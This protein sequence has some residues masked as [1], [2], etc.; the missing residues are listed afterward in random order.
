LFSSGDR[1]RL[2][3]FVC[4]TFLFQAFGVQP[5]LPPSLFRNIPCQAPAMAPHLT[6]QEQDRVVQLKAKGKEPTFILKKINSL[7]H[8]RGVHP[9]AVDA[10]RR[11]LRG[12]THLRARPETRGRK[13]TFSK[14]MV[15]KLN[16]TRKALVKKADGDRQIRWKD[17]LRSARAKKA[18]RTTAKRAFD[19]EGLKVA[20]R[21][22][23]MK[24][25]RT[26]PQEDA[27]M[28]HCRRWRFLPSGYFN[29]SVDLIIDN[30]KFEVPTTDRARAYVK[31]Q[32][33]R[34]QLRTPQEGLKPG[35]TRPNTKK[36]RMHTGGYASVCAGI[37]G[38]KV[39]FWHYLQK[40]WNGE[41]AAAL[42]R[43]PIQSIL[44]KHRGE[45]K[46]YLVCEDNDRTGYK[47]RK[48][49]AAKVESSIQ[50][51]DLPKYSPDLNPLDF[52]VWSEVERRMNKAK[53]KQPESQ[54]KYKARLRRTA[55]GLPA[56]MVKAAVASMKKR[57]Q[58]VYEANGKDIPQ[59]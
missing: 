49:M 29:D 37:S 30:K 21:T 56:S 10:V 14:H 12:K 8:G 27:R 7:R 24:P 54:A 13:R 11:A 23:R 39:V 44:K 31:R 55:L 3:E 15:K 41:A 1:P 4:A 53:V 43:G 35:F 33:V 36:Q 6:P 32:K 58:A 50:T 25:M 9:L 42:Y 19:R 18:H 59:D 17:V 48:A 26:K 47:S 40:T 20:F 5:Q 22:S 2:L 45:K 16:A 57:I 52:F 28:E 34:G 46:K 51:V 38:G